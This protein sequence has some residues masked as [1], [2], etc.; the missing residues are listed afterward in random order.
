MC[1]SCHQGEHDPEWSLE[2]KRAMIVHSNLSGESV[3]SLRRNA[4]KMMKGHGSTP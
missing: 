3:Q 4:G 1:T 2:K